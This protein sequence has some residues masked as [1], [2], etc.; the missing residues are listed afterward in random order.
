MR[1]K[2]QEKIAIT[3]AIH[4]EDPFADIYL[5][6]SRLDDGRKGGDIDL[7]VETDIREKLLN[8]KARILQKIWERIGV[9]RIDIILKTRGAPLN[10]IHRIA[11][12]TGIQL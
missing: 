8:H 7:Y 4:N 3:E 9:Q 5:F 12:K 1:L 10:A 2:E 6:G 11:K